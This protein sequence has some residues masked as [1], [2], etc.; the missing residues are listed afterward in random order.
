MDSGDTAGGIISCTIDGLPA[1]L[2]EPVFDKLQAGLAKAMMSINAAKGFEYG[3]GF[4]G[5][6]M[7]GSE[8]NDAFTGR[9]FRTSTNNSGGI[10]GGISNGM[11]VFFRVAFKPPSSINISQETV[12]KQGNPVEFTAGGRHDVCFLPRAVPIVEAMAALVIADH[13]LTPAPAG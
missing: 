10:Q 9:D 7:K 1:G 4:A 8:H 12:D 6:R 3:S 13:M 2:G 5:T 11:P